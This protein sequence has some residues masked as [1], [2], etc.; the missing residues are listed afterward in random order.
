MCGDPTQKSTGKAR[1]IVLDENQGA[2]VT[3]AIRRMNEED[4]RAVWQIL[5]AAPEAA[6]W[7]EISI[8]N[9]LRDSQTT[10]LLAVCSEEIAGCV[11]GAY[12]AGDAEILNLAVQASFRRKGFAR[13]LVR[14]LLAEWQ[15]RQVVRVFLEVRESNVGAIQLY[16]GMGFRQAGRRRGYYAAPVEDALVLERR[17]Q[18]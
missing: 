15:A 16:E 5:Q 3:A 10:A 8:R 9:S 7:S 11:F 6:E 13:E 18:K 14:H 1:R 2:G 17:G 12:I 4:V